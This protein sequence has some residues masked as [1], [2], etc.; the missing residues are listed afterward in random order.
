M[1]VYQVPVHTRLWLA[2]ALITC[3][4]PQ[5]L[6]GPVWQSLLLGVVVAIR[7]LVDHQRMRLPGRII[8]GG[9]LVAAVGMTWFSFGRIYGP[10]AGVALL[11]NPLLQFLII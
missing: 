5:L 7:W 11:V 6:L 8:R 9:L 3:S 1:R 2:T 10:E 4:L